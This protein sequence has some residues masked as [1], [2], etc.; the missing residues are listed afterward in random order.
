MTPSAS[1]ALP[2]ILIQYAMRI[3]AQPLLDRFGI[4]AGQ[5]LAPELP[6]RAHEA[7]LPS[8]RKLVIVLAGVE[9]RFGVDAIGGLPAT[10]LGYLAIRRHSPAL[11][12]NA[13][14]AGGFESNGDRIGEVF[15]ARDAVHL[16]ARRCE[17]PGLREMGRGAYR[18]PDTETLAGKLGVRRAIVSSGDSLDC[19]AED[20]RHIRASGATLKEMEAGPLGWVCEKLRVPLLPIK[21]VTDFVDHPSPS[22]EQF[23]A[24]Y[25][26]AVEE[27]TRVVARALDILDGDAGCG[28]PVW[29][30]RE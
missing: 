23:L 14:T 16:H 12:I 30:F 15:C 1:S 7:R 2:P 25:G 29:R 17:I 19:S 26:H 24:N 9:E 21:S 18:I 10:L 11:L 8:G 4:A 28:D 13:G 5:P 20:L 22:H 6:F 3:E 27:L